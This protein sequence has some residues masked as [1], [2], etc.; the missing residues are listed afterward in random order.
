MAES[1]KCMFVINTMGHGGAEVALIE[2]MKKMIGLG[3]ETHLYVMLGQ[4]DLISRVPEG[5]KLL[6]KRYD[7][8]DVLS[9]TEKR[10]LYRHT[11]S[12]VLSRFA[13]ARDLPYMVKNYRRMRKAGR[14][15]PEKLLWKPVADG[16]APIKEEYDLAVAFI[17]G[18][19]TYYVAEKV[20]SKT[21]AAFFHIDYGKS[22]YTREL[23]R[24]CYEKIDGVFCVSDETRKSF[25]EAYPEYR[26]KTFVFRNIIDTD[27]IRAKADEGPGFDDGYDGI[28]I[29]TLGRLVKQKALEKSIEAL[30]VIRKRGYEARW[31]VFGEGEERPFLEK[32]IERFGVKDSFFLPGVAQNPYPY[33]K[34]ADIYAHC[35]EYEGQSIAVR[36]AQ[37]LGKPI[38]LSDSNGNRGQ[39]SGGEADGIIVEFTAERIAD[40]IEKLILDPGLRER[41]ART[42]EAKQQS[43]D[44]IRKLIELTKGKKRQ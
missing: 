33:V 8:R 24:G 28:R 21:K 35:S 14:V 4:G 5:V 38:V 34:Q 26:D 9:K 39:I 7:S 3:F 22:G 6:N 20:R 37:V 40:G 29:V 25:V 31:Y 16:T 12:I 2:L 1:K 19:S 32:E 41:L 15:M 42:A 43:N 36:E 10:A 18:A 13:L 17:E 23:D 44:D 11:L 27:L 30:S